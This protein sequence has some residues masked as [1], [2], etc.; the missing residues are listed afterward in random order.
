MVM[1][2]GYI[3]LQGP[4]VTLKFRNTPLKEALLSFARFGGYG[5]VCVDGRNDALD[6]KE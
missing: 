5:F 3:T 2:Q 1:R 6:D 4:H